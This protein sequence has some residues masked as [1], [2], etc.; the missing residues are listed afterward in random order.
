MTPI[1][2]LTP[3]LMAMVIAGALALPL[4]VPSRADDDHDRARAAVQ[5]GEVVPL[6]DVLAQA[7]GD[8][9]GDMVEAE[10]EHHRGRWV[11]ELKLITPGGTLLELVYD[12]ASKDLL[13][14]R[15]HR[16]PRWYRGDPQ[17]LLAAL[18]P[19][20]REHYQRYLDGGGPDG[21]DGD[22]PFAKGG[23]AG[24]RMGYGPGP[25]SLPDDMAE[26]PP[27]HRWGWFRGWWQD[28][29]DRHG[30]GREREEGER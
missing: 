25:G 17:R 7:E 9:I 6:S 5:A 1:R 22:G 13:R 29:H 24:G 21:D 19:R 27:P 11:Y 3:L 30:P 23:G 10:L 4:A 14:A 16:A 12:A 15:G 2:R 8:F 28:D 26:P 20:A 18:P